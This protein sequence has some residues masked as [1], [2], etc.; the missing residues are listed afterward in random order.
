MKPGRIRQTTTRRDQ[1][2]GDGGTSWTSTLV[3]HAARRAD[4]RRQLEDWHHRQRRALRLLN[5]D[6]VGGLALLARQRDN[7]HKGLSGACATPPG[8]HCPRPTYFVRPSERRGCPGTVGSPKISPL[9]HL[10]S[11]SSRP[12]A[13]RRFRSRRCVRLNGL[14]LSGSS[15]GAV[16]VL[17]S[18]LVGGCPQRPDVRKR[19]RWP[20]RSIRP[21][22]VLRP[23][24]RRISACGRSE[25]ADA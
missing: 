20:P 19:V 25:R 22:C 18:G 10:S 4:A 13:R 9:A 1:T 8:I 7:E 3:L 11:S 21:P 16:G 12:A 24:Q 15:G 17:S 6:R 23:V 14:R 5:R 2:S